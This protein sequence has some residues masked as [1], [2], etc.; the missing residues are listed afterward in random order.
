M[1]IS[2][3]KNSLQKEQLEGRP[4]R[5]HTGSVNRKV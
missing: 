3:Q 2:L 4:P 5:H 1:H